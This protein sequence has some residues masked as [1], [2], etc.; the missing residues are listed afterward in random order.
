MPG[1]LFMTAPFEIAEDHGCAV[2]FRKPINLVVKK[3]LELVRKVGGGHVF[4]PGCP[5][6]MPPP[7]GDRG[8]GTRSGPVSDLVQPRAQRIP[9]PERASLAHQD[10]ERRLEGIL[11]VMRVGQHAATDAQHHRTVPLDECR[12]CQLGGLISIGRELLQE[13]TI[14]P[15]LKRADAIERAKMP[16]DC[17]IV[18]ESHACKPHCSGHFSERYE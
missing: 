14:R 17:T 3:P 12:K 9:H 8:P 10:Q 15:L 4:R 13:L 18:V 5:T 2:A 6:L 11:H 16:D 1:R 7:P